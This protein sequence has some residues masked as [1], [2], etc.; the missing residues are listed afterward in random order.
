MT[1]QVVTLKPSDQAVDAVERML[2]RRLKL[3]P[4]VDDDGHVLGVLTRSRLLAL[5]FN[6]QGRAAGGAL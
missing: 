6:G 2:D 3:V 1:R 5:I 4:V